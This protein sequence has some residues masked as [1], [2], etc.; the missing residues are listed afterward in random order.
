VSTPP[1]LKDVIRDFR[2]DQIID[3]ARRLFGERGS[4][5][6]SM[7]EI[8]GQAGVARS[9]VYVYFENRDELLRAC[10]KQ[11]H[12]QLTEAISKA[13][14]LAITPMER[15]EALLLGIFEQLDQNPAFIRLALAIQEMPRSGGAAVGSELAVIGLDIAGLLGMVVD[16]GMASGTFRILDRDQAITLIGQQIYGAVSVR[17]ADPDPKPRGRAATELCDFL[18]HGLES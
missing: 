5:D 8:A 13:W 14:D 16:D 10:L 7:D 12:H 2:R 18:L 17:S 3:V 15:L 9:T 1:A 4:V 11:I 6:V